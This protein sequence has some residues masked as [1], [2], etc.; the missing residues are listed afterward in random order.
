MVHF[1]VYVWRNLRSANRCFS[2]VL[3]CLTQS[4]FPFKVRINLSALLLHSGMHTKAG[5]DAIQGY[6]IFF[7]VIRPLLSAMIMPQA[8]AFGYIFS[9]CSKIVFNILPDWLEDLLP[10]LIPERVNAYAFPAALNISDEYGGLAF[11]KRH[12]R[13]HIRVP[14][15]IDGSTNTG[16]IMCL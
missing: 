10:I 5:E 13:C 14:H 6:L 2:I 7:K 1:S 9:G 3:K 12:S 4:K 11:F 8:E 16:A 15:C